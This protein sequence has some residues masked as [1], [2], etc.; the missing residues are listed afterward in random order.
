MIRIGV[1]AMGGD[2]APFEALKGAV[3]AQSQLTD[4]QIVLYG[5]ESELEQIAQDEGWDLSALE[6]VDCPDV[7]GMAEHPVRAF[8]S[9]PQ[10][11]LSVGFQQLAQKNIHAFLSAGNTGA[12][13]V[14]S[15]HVVK[16]VEG[17][18]RPCLTAVVPRLEGHPGIL[19]D[20]GANS[21]CKPEHLQQFAVLGSLLAKA[22]YN[23]EAPKVALLNIGEEPEKGNLMSKAAHQL[24][25]NT[26]TINF[27]GNIEGRDIFGSAADVIVCD[28]FTGNTIVKVCEGMY[29]RLAKRGVED[30]YLDKFNFKHYGGSPILGVNAPVIVGHGIT[31]SDTFVKMIELAMDTVKSDL[32]SMVQSSMKALQQVSL[33]GE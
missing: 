20:V 29:Y 14:G 16:P 10:A 28:G 13:L 5:V 17:L 32:V 6:I 15:L 26:D 33:H 7:I 25:A 2:F 21:D 18:D 31:K 19:L 9:K 27:V 8:T 3:L 24:L 22:L 12:M 4:C 23:L 1:D 30:D 11:S